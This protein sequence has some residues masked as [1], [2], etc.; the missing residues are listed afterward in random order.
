[1][2]LAPNVFSAEIDNRCVLLD[3]AQDRYVALG[4]AATRALNALVGAR[5]DGEA[6]AVAGRHRAELIARGIVTDQGAPRHNPAVPTPCASVA[7]GDLGR[8]PPV[9]AAQALG[10]LRA[11]TEVDFVLRR[12]SFEQFVSWLR[13]Q[14]ARRRGS[15]RIG[16]L[17]EE[18]EGFH[19]IRPWFPAS[20]ICRLD[21]PALALK[22][23]RA[24][25]DV[26]LVF[27]VRLEPFGAHCWVQQG[28]AVLNDSLDL[29]AQYSAIMAI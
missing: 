17:R 21:A 14:K 8:S 10:A 11:L 23:W 28:E 22:L 25:R 24:G 6:M 15:R 19:A 20:S 13:R 16:D 4:A 5:D 7:A 26:H 1:M 2:H 18:I 3:L 27:G 9:G 29:V 12:R